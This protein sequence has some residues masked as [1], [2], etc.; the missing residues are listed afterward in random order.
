MKNINITTSKTGITCIWESG[1]AFTNTGNA[2]VVGDNF[3]YPKKAIFIKKHG[4]LACKEHAL[5][6]IKKG[7][8]VLNIERSHDV[9]QLSWY[10]IA[11]VGRDCAAIEP[12]DGCYLNDGCINMLNAAVKKSN[13]YHCREAI[14]IA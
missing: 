13:I 4:D 1:G 8:I 9:Y 5:I 12:I 7:D 11:Q 3:G 14:Y 10:R 6:P 2:T